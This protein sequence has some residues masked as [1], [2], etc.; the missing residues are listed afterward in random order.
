MPKPV[1]TT[2][3]NNS[4]VK[5]RRELIVTKAIELFLRQGYHG[6]TTRMLAEAC[7]LSG[8]GLYQYIGSKRDVLHLIAIDNVRRSKALAKQMQEEAQKGVVCALREYIRN[9]TLAGDRTRDR[10]L[11]I[12]REIRNFTREDRRLL[13]KAL[14][15]NVQTCE[16][17]LTKGVESGVFRINNS[18]LLAHE[19]ALIAYNWG[20][21]RWLL[22][23]YT[24]I[25]EYIR[26]WTDNILD[27]IQ[28]D[29][30]NRHEV[31]E[32]KMR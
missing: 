32:M 9:R 28:V 12:N 10:N 15:D 30:K 3:K 4:L 5:E 27:L 14:V 18:F 22:G 17:L 21:R 25:E 2:I 1:R 16:K 24:T 31:E 6:T 8:A 20:Q 19:I 23:R 13:L 7:G 29:R 11:L 26:E